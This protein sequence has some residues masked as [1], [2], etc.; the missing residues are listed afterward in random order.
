M[1]SIT[2]LLMYVTMDTHDSAR[3]AGYG[4][5]FWYSAANLTERMTAGMKSTKHQPILAQKPFCITQTNCQNN[6]NSKL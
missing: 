1:L 2:Y 4:S 5:D 3:G 6:N